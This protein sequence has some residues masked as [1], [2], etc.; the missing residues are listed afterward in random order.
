MYTVNFGDLTFIGQGAIATILLSLGTMAISLPV[1]ILVGLV[2][3]VRKPNI[4]VAGIQ[5]VL[6]IVVSAVR[7]TPLMAQL[8]F[9][10]FGLPMMG[11]E[12]PSVTAALLGLSLY[13]VAYLA[14][15]V[16]GGIDSVAKDQWD[17]ATT[18]GLNYLRTMRHVILPQAL[19]IMLPPSVSFFIGLIKDSSLCAVIGFVELARAGRIIVERTN[20]S[21]LI[22]AVVALVY[23]VIC[24]PLSMFSQRLE[25]A[26]KV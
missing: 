8:I 24:Y 21:L 9:L 25:R 15:I 3:S 1:A 23:F 2:R 5:F 19:R 11:I 20:Q 7:G 18:L 14:E 16:R 22:F 10:F 12:M 4:L 26:L 13:S 6:T 17:A